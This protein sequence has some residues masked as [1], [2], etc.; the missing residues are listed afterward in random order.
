MWRLPPFSRQGV[1]RLRR[2]RGE[3]A[4]D[5]EAVSPNVTSGLLTKAEGDAALL[6]AEDELTDEEIAAKVG[7]TKRT[8]ER[9]KKRAD[10]LARVTAHKEAFKDR[11]LTE[12]FADKRARIALL[13]S[14]AQ[15]IARWL[16][17]NAYERTEVK[18]AANGEAIEYKI[19][20]QP[21]YSQ[22]R[23][24]LDDIAKE[25]GERATKQEITGAGGEPLV[26]TIVGVD[27]ERV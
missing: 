7:I 17:E 20:D 27:V 1:R 2:L 11:A 9:W 18:V 26:L 5:D 3:V 22:L 12:G 13:N 16:A 24:A 4:G 15:D 10:I 8:V 21:R 25:M 6:I 19:F 23:G 14:T